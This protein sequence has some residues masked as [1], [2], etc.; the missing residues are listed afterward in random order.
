MLG[1]FGGLTQRE[2]A[3]LLGLGTGVAVSCQ[4][5]RLGEELE[6]D[7]ELGDLVHRLEK[8]L[9]KALILYSKG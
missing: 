7:S 6:D 9:R 3:E 4:L 5:K 1:R 2:I 8:R